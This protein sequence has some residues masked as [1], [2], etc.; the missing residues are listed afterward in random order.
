VTSGVTCPNAKPST[1]HQ[2]RKEKQEG[3][4]DREYSICIYI[5][6]EIL[7]IIMIIT[8]LAPAANTW[9][10]KLAGSESWN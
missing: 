10:R 4:N 3:R 1:R 8:L 2:K 7:L 6:T 5:V 9:W